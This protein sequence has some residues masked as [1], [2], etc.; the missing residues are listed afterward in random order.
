MLLFFLDLF[1]AATV[2][3]KNIVAATYVEPSQNR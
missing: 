1:K 3:L 2:F